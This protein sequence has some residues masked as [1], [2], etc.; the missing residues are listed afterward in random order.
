[1]QEASLVLAGLA[2]CLSV[3]SLVLVHSARRTAL[4]ATEVPE[5]PHAGGSTVFPPDPRW[6]DRLEPIVL[7]LVREVMALRETKIRELEEAGSPLTDSVYAKVYEETAL[8]A[9]NWSGPSSG[10][11]KLLW[12]FLGTRGPE[13]GES[14]SELAVLRRLGHGP[15]AIERY[16]QQARDLMNRT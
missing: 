12:Q 5:G 9:W 14:W 8:L 16:R 6:A 1:M 10:Q 2:A 11:Q 7:D 3:A 13:R 15:D 4:Q